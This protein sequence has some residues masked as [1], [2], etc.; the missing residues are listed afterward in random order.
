MGMDTNTQ[1]PVKSGV[2]VRAT[3]LESDCS[4]SIGCVCDDDGV[5]ESNSCTKFD[6]LLG[7]CRGERDDDVPVLWQK[8]HPLNAPATDA[9]ITPNRLS[10]VRWPLGEE[11]Y[12]DTPGTDGSIGAAHKDASEIED[13]EWV[14][15]QL[16]VTEHPDPDPNQKYLLVRGPEIKMKCHLCQ[17]PLYIGATKSAKEVLEEGGYGVR[18]DT[19]H[20]DERV[21]ACV[22]E[23]GHTTQLRYD[24]AL[25]LRK[26]V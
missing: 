21:A 18:E 19:K 3:E 26:D 15:V 25:R 22:C 5:C 6:E 2:A 10:N 9:S 8:K 13:G 14:N 4:E 7:Q 24:F 16:D 23:N 12:N 11:P 20:Q 17:T 1:E